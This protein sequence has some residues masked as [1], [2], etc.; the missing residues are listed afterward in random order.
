MEIARLTPQQV[1]ESAVIALGLGDVG[2]D[3][4]STEAM[5]ASLR[6]AA[7]FHCPATSGQVVRSVIEVLEGLPGF[8]DDIKDQLEV[9]LDALLGCGDLFELPVE[10]ER[11]TSSRIFLG[12]P[13]FVRR[14]SGSH[15]LLGVRPDGASLVGDD[16]THLMTYEGHARLVPP[17]SI[18]EDLIASSDLVEL[19]PEQWLKVPPIVPAGH[20]IEQFEIRLS[21][22][23]PSGDIEHAR[24]LDPTQPV[25][26]YKARWRSPKP[27]DEGC[28]VARRPQ[29]YGSELWCFAQ[30]AAGHIIQ[31]I[32]LPVNA[33]LS[34]ATDEAWR[35]QA[36]IDATAGHPQRLRIREGSDVTSVLDFFSPVPS[37]AQRRLDFIGTPLL[38]GRGALFSYAISSAELVEELEFLA[39][40]LWIT[41]SDQSERITK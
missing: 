5:A 13:A 38:R 24:I 39:D 27:S 18:A 30:V 1:A 20:L 41:S 31:L 19:T 33:T 25:D 35:L 16:L 21:A 6:R 12:P 17:S 15:L 28:F 37:W 23:G 40:T 29:A 4:T 14:A 2:V 8:Q 22:A 36:A 34:R 3:L 11:G 9:L 26:F 7:S 10:G 32:D